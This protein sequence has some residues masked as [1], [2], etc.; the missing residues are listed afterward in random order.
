MKI[1]YA[2]HD[3]LAVYGIGITP[4]DALADAADWADDI[5]C[6]DIH[7][8]DP[9]YA[10]NILENGFGPKDAFFVDR[11]NVIQKWCYQEWVE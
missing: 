1:Y 11:D 2:S 6:L 3:D 8:I 5:D 9:V 7:R 10:Q 4:D